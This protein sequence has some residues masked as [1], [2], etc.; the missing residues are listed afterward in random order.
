[1]SVHSIT[2]LGGRP[3]KGKTMNFTSSVVCKMISSVSMECCSRSEIECKQPFL[4]PAFLA[5]DYDHEQ[6]GFALRIYWNV[7]D[8]YP[9]CLFPGV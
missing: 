9:I 1:M 6:Y 4:L 8:S 5:E 3:G 2:K 7:S